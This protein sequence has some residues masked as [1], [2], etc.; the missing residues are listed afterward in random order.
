M[1]S[2]GKIQGP[3]ARERCE[4]PLHSAQARV[5]PV[6]SPQYRGVPEIPERLTSLPSPWSLVTEL[7]T[8][9]I[10]SGAPGAAYT[11]S[12]S[13]SKFTGT[14][15]PA[16]TGRIVPGSPLTACTPALSSCSSSKFFLLQKKGAKTVSTGTSSFS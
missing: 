3:P 10:H 5:L 15:A 11:A 1:R 12:T 7:T 14:Y 9:R 4:G 16:L 2:L 13:V 8:S 6:G